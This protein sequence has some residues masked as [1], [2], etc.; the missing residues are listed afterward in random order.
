MDHEKKYQTDFLISDFF[1]LRDDEI[2]SYFAKMRC[3]NAEIVSWS[4]FHFLIS[5]RYHQ[6]KD[7]YFPELDDFG[8][9]FFS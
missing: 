8:K 2:D 7:G 3:N 1:G 6:E 5:V 9:V 4:F